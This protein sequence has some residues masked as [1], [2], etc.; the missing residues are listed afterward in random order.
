MDN[1]EYEKESELSEKIK[2]LNRA[3]ISLIEELNAIIWY[4][5]RA[6][7]TKNESLKKVLN[8]NKLDEY[9]H[10]SRLLE[11]IRRNDP[12]FEDT[13]KEFLFSNI[14]LGED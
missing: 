7:A 11:W 4:D 8:H 6:Y 9:E 3:R 13:L 10:A 14:D 5:A 12:K 2:D 1:Y